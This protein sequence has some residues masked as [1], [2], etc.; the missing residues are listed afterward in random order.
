MLVIPLELRDIEYFAA[1]AKHAHVGRAA[2]ALRLT[3]PALSKSL[4]RLEQAVGAKLVK[5]TPKG[6]ELTPEGAT[7]ESHVRQLRISLADVAREISDINAGRSGQ[8]RLGAAPGVVD[9]LLLSACS[10]F[11]KEAP[12]VTLTVIVA[13]NDTLLPALRN[14]ELDLILCG[15]PSP[16]PDDVLHEP[17]LED[18]LVVFASARHPLALRKRVSIAEIALEHWAMTV[19]NAQEPN[20]PQK[21]LEDNGVRHPKVMMKTSYLP[22]RDQVVARSDLLG[23]SSRRYLHHLA[24]RLAVVELP[25]PELKR[26]RCV[27]VCYRRQAYLSPAARRL[28]ALLKSTAA[29]VR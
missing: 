27:A 2:E 18:E 19:L 23:V 5:R 17:L 25:V 8:V 13:A 16:P 22:L 29:N 4:R 21:A 6:I 15:V 12:N 20:L 24:G 14:A 3:Q 9:D 11:V 1:I 7:L 10:A 26:K 28:I